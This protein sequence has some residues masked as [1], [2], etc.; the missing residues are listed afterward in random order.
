MKTLMYD[1]RQNVFELQS[2]LRYLHSIE[3]SI[4]LINPD[5]IFG[6]ETTEAVLAV[7]RF[8]AVPETGIVDF[9]TWE[10]IF[11]PYL[12]RDTDV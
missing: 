11:E 3:E 4:P 7:Q 6:N 1:R 2:G 5:G 9:E 12:S 10:L 8:F